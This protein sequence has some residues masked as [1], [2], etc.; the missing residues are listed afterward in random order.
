M[1]KDLKHNRT[2]I[3]MNWKCNFCTELSTIIADLNN[4]IHLHLLIGEKLSISK[5]QSVRNHE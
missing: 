2:F 4:F 5:F 1:G 3:V